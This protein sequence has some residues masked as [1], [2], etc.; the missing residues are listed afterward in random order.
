MRVL[1]LSSLRWIH[2][3]HHS[4]HIHHAL[5][6]K[7]SPCRT[8]AASALG[9]ATTEARMPSPLPF[10]ARLCCASQILQA[11]CGG[12]VD[13]AATRPR[14]FV[15]PHANQDVAAAAHSTPLPD[16]SAR[17]RVSRAG[18]SE[19]L[20]ARRGS[21]G[22]RASASALGPR[23]RDPA[24]S[25]AAAAAPAS[26]VCACC[27]CT[28]RGSAEVQLQAGAAS[29]CRRAQWAVPQ[30]STV[31]AG[32]ACAGCPAASMQAHAMPA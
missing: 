19:A 10:P 18:G 26:G 28:A 14:C 7:E 30:C 12:A 11:R 17:P 25:A 22:R 5:G 23:Q 21:S 6:R 8:E 2:D 1:S 29:A 16:R 31:V 32:A 4:T 9:H 24:A 20:W 27:A 13:E 15:H 3:T